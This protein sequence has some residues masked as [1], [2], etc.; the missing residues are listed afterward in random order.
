MEQIHKRS[1]YRIT[2]AL[3]AQLEWAGAESGA[4]QGES[5]PAVVTTLSG[6]GAQ[7]F[8]RQLPSRDILE[9][10]LS[11]PEG[12]VEE[13]AKRR[14]PGRDTTRLPVPRQGNPTGAA[15]R[16]QSHLA[17][18]RAHVVETRVT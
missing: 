1:A 4:R 14:Q 8:L 7:V 9:L 10:T 18:I 16:R 2:V 12:F 6:G 3:R 13:Q 5:G 17:G 11:T 15:A